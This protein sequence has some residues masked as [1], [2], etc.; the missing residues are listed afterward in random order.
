[1][2]VRGLL[3]VQHADPVDPAAGI[4]DPE[5]RIKH[6][7]KCRR[8]AQLLLLDERSFVRVERNQAMTYAEAVK[9]CITGRVMLLDV[10]ERPVLKVVAGDGYDGR[11]SIDLGGPLEQ[12]RLPFLEAAVARMLNRPH[13]ALDMM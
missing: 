5:A 3:A 9:D 6:D 11:S 10:L 8:H 7:G 4:P 12:Q 13:Y 2:N 1:V